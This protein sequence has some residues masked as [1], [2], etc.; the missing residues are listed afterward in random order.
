[1]VAIFSFFDKWKEFGAYEKSISTTVSDSIHYAPARKGESKQF[2]VNTLQLGCEE[3]HWLRID[4]LSPF[5]LLR[6]D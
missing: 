2:L 6:S 1:M 4:R 5:R 3:F